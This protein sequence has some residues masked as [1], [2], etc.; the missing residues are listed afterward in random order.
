V[1]SPDAQG[2]DAALPSSAKLR[3]VGE[4]LPV[5]PHQT[6]AWTAGQTNL[7]KEFVDATATLFQQGL[8]DPRGC[9]YREIE[10][11]VVGSERPR[12]DKVVTTHGWV[13]PHTGPR[14]QRFGVCWNGLV[15]PVALI[16]K[17]ADVRADALIAATT[18]KADIEGALFGTGNNWIPNFD[19]LCLFHPAEER[20]ISF[21]L[22]LPI[23][24][25][26]LLRLGEA[27]L[28]E[29]VWNRWTSGLRSYSS[30]L[31]RVLSVEESVEPNKV[32]LRDPYLV[33][34]NCWTLALFDQAEAAHIR[35]DDRLA[36]AS[37]KMLNS[38]WSSVKNEA[39]KRGFREH[40]EKENPFPPYFLIK[41]NRIRELLTDQRRRAEDRKQ[42]AGPPVLSS[43]SRLRN[44][45]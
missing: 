31:G 21:D 8:A 3:L 22:P 28:A 9:D 32:I 25:C 13:I 29:R 18:A 26:L 5:P 41:P 42:G 19:N 24:A 14:A 30:E 20:S 33:L 1:C 16:G 40:T 6:T 39:E 4:L 23:K 10:V 34:A 35:R 27:E 17:P 11:L 37:V 45:L 15:Y 44:V 7:S 2:Q 36:L 38:V 43:Q 12:S